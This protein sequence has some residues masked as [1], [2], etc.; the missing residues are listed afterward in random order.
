[1]RFVTDPLTQVARALA[2]AIATY[3][4]VR[5]AIEDAIDQIQYN[6]LRNQ[7][8]V[9]LRAVGETLPGTRCDPPPL[10]PPGSIQP[11]S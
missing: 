6:S 3:P 5:A 4:P 10:P 7:L 1:M 9:D 8:C 11:L 2:A